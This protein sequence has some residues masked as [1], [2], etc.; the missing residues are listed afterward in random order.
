[1][2]WTK[3]KEELQGSSTRSG[4]YVPRDTAVRSPRVGTNDSGRYWNTY[5]PLI[6]DGTLESFESGWE[7]FGAFGWSV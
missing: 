6:F 2:G 5:F 3:G 7:I 1:M 4:G